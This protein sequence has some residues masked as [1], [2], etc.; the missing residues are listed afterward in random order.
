MDPYFWM[1]ANDRTLLKISKTNLK[2]I[3]TTDSPC[4]SDGT[5]PRKECMLKMVSVDSYIVFTLMIKW[6]Q[7]GSNT[8]C[9]PF[10]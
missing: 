2:S 7:A 8:R 6:E 4:A 10:F 9:H 3:S 5:L 1:N